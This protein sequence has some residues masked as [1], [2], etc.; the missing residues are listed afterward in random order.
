MEASRFRADVNLGNVFKQRIKESTYTS[1][2][3]AS[4]ACQVQFRT[5]IY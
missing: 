2:R 4:A 1:L 3:V 5:R